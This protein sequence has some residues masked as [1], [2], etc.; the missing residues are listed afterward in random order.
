MKPR[1]DR[2]ETYNRNIAIPCGNCIN[3]MFKIFVCK[4]EHEIINS[5][6]EVWE[7]SKEEIFKPDLQGS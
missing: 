6:K 1:I 5:A 4:T 3:R 7:A 2:G